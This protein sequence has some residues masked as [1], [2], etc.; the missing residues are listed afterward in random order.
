MNILENLPEDKLITYAGA[1]CVS[2]V[3][4]GDTILV[5]KSKGDQLEEICVRLI[6]VDA[7]EEGEPFYSEAKK[8][9]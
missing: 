2:K 5:L 7:P 8:L 9:F 4:D 1:G 6:G 3:V